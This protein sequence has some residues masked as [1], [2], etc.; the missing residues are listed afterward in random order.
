MSS[1]V[2]VYA[3]RY[4][5]T[6]SVVEL[7]RTEL[8]AAGLEQVELL[9][10][11]EADAQRI[12][13]ADL[14]VIGGPI[15]AGRIIGDIPKFCDSHRELLTGRPVGIFI[16]CLYDGEQAASQ[17][18]EAFPSWL[19]GHACASADLGGQVKLQ[20]LKF[21]DRFLMHNIAKVREDVD[22]I[23]V[24]AVRAFAADL[25]ACL[26]PSGSVEDSAVG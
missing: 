14:V 15:Y 18:V 9:P 19:H 12:N 26:R 6:R 3:T 10:V 16:T 8:V 4:G 2:I 13:G 24:P 5:T 20:R 7:I 23:R 22:R 1:A 11:A 17:L 21:I 25:V